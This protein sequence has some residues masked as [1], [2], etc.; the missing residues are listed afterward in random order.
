MEKEILKM[1]ER[2]MVIENAIVEMDVDLLK[3]MGFNKRVINWLKTQA[4]PLQAWRRWMNN[5]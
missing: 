5:I 4:D 3:D 2:T 1:E